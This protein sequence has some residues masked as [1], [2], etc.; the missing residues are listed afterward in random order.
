MIDRKL[1]EKISNTVIEHPKFVDTLDRLLAKVRYDVSVGFALTVGLTGVGKTKVLRHL[2]YILFNWV[3]KNPKLGFSAPIALSMHSPERK[4]FSWRD[5]YLDS[6]VTALHEPNA[7]R[8][9]DLKR[10]HDNYL[11]SGEPRRYAS[12]TIADL[13]QCFIRAVNDR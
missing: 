1:P 11:L 13:R 5:F 10:M 7:T 4:L 6:L 9:D 8:K 3:Q 12:K 2:Q